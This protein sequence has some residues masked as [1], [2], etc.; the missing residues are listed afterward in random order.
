MEVIPRQGFFFR[1]PASSLFGSPQADGGFRT[2]TANKLC[3]DNAGCPVLFPKLSLKD[4]R[5]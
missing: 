3:F 4:G 1:P 5:R 2:S